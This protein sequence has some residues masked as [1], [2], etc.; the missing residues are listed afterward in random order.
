MDHF[1]FDKLAKELLEENQDDELQFII[2]LIDRSFWIKQRASQ[3]P[4]FEPSKNTTTKRRSK[5]KLSFFKS[6]SVSDDFVDNLIG[7]F[8]EKQEEPP[9][10][11]DIP[12]YPA[13]DHNHC[14]FPDPLKDWDSN[15]ED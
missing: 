4:K 9:I 2:Q 13:L 15:I 10:V 12:P 7:N 14:M 8:E 6:Q 3:L 1:L 5:S 11:H